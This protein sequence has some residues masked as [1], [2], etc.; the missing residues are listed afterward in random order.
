MTATHIIETKLT[1]AGIQYRKADIVVGRS[2]KTTCPTCSHTRKKK[3]DPCLSVSIVDDGAIWRCHN[4]GD[5]GGCSDRDP[6]DG[7]APAP[8][9]RQHHNPRRTDYQPPKH[10]PPA[11]P[12]LTPAALAWFENER[13]ITAATLARHGVYSTTAWFPQVKAERPAVAF[14]YRVG[15]EVI[16]IKYRSGEKHFAQE[17][18]CRPC[19]YNWDHA[20]E[21]LEA[22]F[23]QLVVAEGEIDVLALAEAGVVAVSLRDG[24][25]EEAKY[26]EADKRFLAL[27]EHP[28]LSAF[29]RIVIATDN[30][31]AGNALADELAFRFGK[32]RCYRV[33]WPEFEGATIK[34]AN[35]CLLYHGPEIT[36][37]AIATARPWPVDGVSRVL[38]HLDEIVDVYHGRLARPFEIT[39]VTA[40]QRLVKVIPGSL[41]VITGYPNHG[42]SNFLDQVAVHL[43]EQYGW[44]FAVFS[45][46]HTVRDHAIRL[47]EKRVGRPFHDGPTPRMT[48]AE[49][50]DAA[51]WVDERFA[52]ITPGE[53]DIATP[54]WIIDKARGLALRMGIRGL[55]VDPFNEIAQPPQFG[56]Q[57]EFVSSMLSAFKKFARA[58][59]LVAFMVA[60]PK[61]VMRVNGKLPVPG[62]G[63]ILGSAHFNAKA[64]AG[65]TVHR[66]DLADSNDTK[67]QR[68]Q[69][70]VTKVREQP[71]MGVA[72]D[73][74]TLRFNGRTRR[75]ELATGEN[76]EPDDDQQ[77]DI[78][79]RR[80]IHG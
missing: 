18:N 70:F 37:Q 8:Y 27:G 47:I 55:L 30:D 65:I 13:G 51:R 42:K 39:D 5:R 68:T 67:G 71:R 35:D 3:S 49:A 17:K 57:T 50:I 21:G 74:T 76:A 52:W 28:E 38:D 40:L 62:L 80:D 43:S 6:R 72:G 23:P 11:N 45:P 73:F 48:V 1:E 34:D 66:P 41:V 59:E 16:A 22:E 31:E 56:T 25:P 10:T 26:D 64:D 12:T 19:L 29:T 61:T 58:H 63:D 75:Y 9:K 24:A 36:A 7:A 78:N 79:F 2:F 54:D 60:H 44:R 46:E 4:C 20:A 14:P 32:G 15:E 69:V 53:D 77:E 33:R